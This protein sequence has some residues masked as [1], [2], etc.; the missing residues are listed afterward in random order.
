MPS[1]F[2]IVLALVNIA[3]RSEAGRGAG[4]MLMIMAAAALGN[5]TSV[6][7]TIVT[8]VIDDLGHYDTAVY[9]PASPTPAL[10]A[11][12][13]G[14]VRLG[15]HYTY[16]FCSP[17]RRSFLSGRLPVHMTGAQAQPCTNWLPLEMEILP[18]KLKKAGFRS[19]VIG[20]GHWGYQTIDHLPINRGFES[21]VGYLCGAENYDHGYNEN[22]NMKHD[23]SSTPA[24]CVH[25]MWNGNAPGYDVIANITYSTNFYSRRATALIE[26]APPTEP[27]SLFLLYQGVHVPYQAVPA[28]E[29]K[30]TPP[31]MWDQTYSNMLRV[32]DGGVANITA[33]LRA[34][35]RWDNTFLFV[36]SDNG[37]IMKVRARAR[38]C[39]VSPA[40][41][42]SGS[43]ANA[44]RAH[45]HRPSFPPSTRGVSSFPAIRALTLA[46][47]RTR[48]AT[49]TP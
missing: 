13:D 46:F 5:P 19:H 1:D 6:L 4:G 35:K 17:T 20:K 12:A 28:W 45:L 43:G 32:V 47:V 22:R 9:N 24:Q 16:K 14:G 48:R 10:K 2:S 25:D 30:P 33:A 3:R 26:A 38:C 23:C 39:Y 11:L 15:R 21:H 18:Q 42:A 37:G 41:F 40:R 8:I 31:G 29:S 36:T 44:A 34:T 49:T 27:L 7:R